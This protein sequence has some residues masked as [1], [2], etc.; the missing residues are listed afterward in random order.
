MLPGCSVL[1]LTLVAVF[2]MAPSG[3]SSLYR[4]GSSATVSS[5]S[6]VQ[7]HTV[8]PP[9]SKTPSATLASPSPPVSRSEP[10]ISQRCWPEADTLSTS[11]QLPS[12]LKAKS[13]PPVSMRNT[14]T[15]TLD[16]GWKSASRAE[17]TTSLVP[18]NCAEMPSGR[19]EVWARARVMNAAIWP[20]LTVPAGS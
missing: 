2:V 17:T 20:R 4:S 18:S 13:M 16:I 3:M 10:S 19:T 7:A 5:L 14:S 12:P 11:P 9:L 15:V 8:V 6:P 1:I